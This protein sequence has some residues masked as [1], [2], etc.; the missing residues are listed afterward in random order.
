M[1]SYAYDT[2]QR[3]NPVG[4]FGMVYVLEGTSVA[5]ATRVAETLKHEL[6]LSDEAFVYLTSHGSIDQDHVRF[7]ESLLNRIDADEDRASVIHAA[8]RFFHLYAQVFRTLPDK[9]SALGR[10]EL[11][12]VA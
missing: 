2:I 8:R 7:L 1:V 9:Q 3:V 10:P 6:E 5:L 12:D 11:R 4:F